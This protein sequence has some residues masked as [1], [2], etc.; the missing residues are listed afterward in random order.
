KTTNQLP[1][2]K[3]NS[4]LIDQ[5]TFDAGPLA[6]I[7]IAENIFGATGAQ[8]GDKL[9]LVRNGDQPGNPNH[10]DSAQFNP[11]SFVH[12]VK[13]ID[14]NGPGTNDGAFIR[15]FE[16]RFSQVPEPPSVILLLTAAGAAV[17]MWSRRT[18]C[19]CP[20]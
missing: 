10:F 1:I 6:T 19:K 8:I 2:I 12:V 9:V 5:W 16:Q 3:D 18:K 13:V 7:Q 11:T 20:S 15:R 17:L 14:I 4:L